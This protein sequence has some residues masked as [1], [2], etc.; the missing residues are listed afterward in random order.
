MPDAEFGVI[1]L[2]EDR[3]EQRLDGGGGPV[4]AAPVEDDRRPAEVAAGPCGQRLRPQRMPDPLRQ[5]LEGEE[6]QLASTNATVPV[7]SIRQSG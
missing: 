1:L 5:L 2:L 6:I 7:A 3:L 4:P